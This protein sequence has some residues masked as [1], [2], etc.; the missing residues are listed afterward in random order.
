MHVCTI[1]NKLSQQSILIKYVYEINKF[2]F[3]LLINHIG[4]PM[5][6]NEGNSIKYFCKNLESN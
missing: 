4:Q 3:H 2:G 5:S 1:I 6:Y